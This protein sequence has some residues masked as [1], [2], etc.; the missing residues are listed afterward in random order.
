[1]KVDAQVK[2]SVQ[3][4]HVIQIGKRK[5]LQPNPGATLVEDKKATHLLAIHFILSTSL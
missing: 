3:N 2:T 4:F 1:M 5:L